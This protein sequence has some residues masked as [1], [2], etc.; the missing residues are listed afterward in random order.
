[1][2][3]LNKPFINLSQTT[4]RVHEFHSHHC[5]QDLY[6]GLASH[7]HQMACP[8]DEDGSGGEDMETKEYGK[9]CK[10]DLT[11]AFTLQPQSLA[12]TCLKVVPEMEFFCMDVYCIITTL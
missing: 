10:Q 5:H 11:P 12:E 1:M 4:I 9:S 8:M 6:K 2:H 7:G 3:R